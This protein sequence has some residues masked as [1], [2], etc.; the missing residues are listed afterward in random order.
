MS[1]RKCNYLNVID[2]ESTCWEGVDNRNHEKEIIEIGIVPIDM[3]N[4]E[5]IGKYGFYVKPIKSEVSKFCTEITGITEETLKH[6][7]SY[8]EIMNQ[9]ALVKLGIRNRP[10]LSWGNDASLFKKE[11][12]RHNVRGPCHIHLDFKILFA[13]FNGYKYGCGLRKALDI[14]GLE[15]KGRYHSGA[16]DAYNTARLF[17]QF[18]EKYRKVL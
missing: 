9:K 17:I 4:L 18:V 15:F 6:A 3:R 8:K 7:P 16:D 1:F 10:W 13:L 2:L 14:S 11:S 12:E 5:I